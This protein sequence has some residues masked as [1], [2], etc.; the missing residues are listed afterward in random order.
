MITIE[1]LW[2]EYI[3]EINLSFMS[4]Y[5]AQSKDFCKAKKLHNPISLIKLTE[6][7]LKNLKKQIT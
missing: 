4:N 6:E 1:E 7:L 3:Q 5:S 2:Q